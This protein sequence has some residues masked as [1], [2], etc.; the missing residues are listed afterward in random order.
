MPQALSVNL[1]PRRSSNL[2]AQKS[3]GPTNDIAFHLKASIDSY[4]TTDSVAIPTSRVNNLSCNASVFYFIEMQHQFVLDEWNNFHD[5]NGNIK[6]LAPGAAEAARSSTIIPSI[7]AAAAPSW[8]AITLQG[9]KTNHPTAP[10]KFNYLPPT[11]Q[12]AM[13]NGYSIGPLMQWLQSHDFSDKNNQ[14]TSSPLPLSSRTLLD[15]LNNEMS[16]SSEFG[17]SIP[18][19]E[20]RFL[21]MLQTA[22]R[23]GMTD[24]TSLTA[25]IFQANRPESMHFT[26]SESEINYPIYIPFSNWILE[27]WDETSLANSQKVIVRDENN[28]WSASF[29]KI[30]ESF[31]IHTTILLQLQGM[32]S[33]AVM[34]LNSWCKKDVILLK[35][36]ANRIADVASSLSIPGASGIGHSI[37]Q[38]V[39]KYEMI[40]STIME[41]PIQEQAEK[42]IEEMEALADQC[43]AGF[44]EIANLN[45]KDQQSLKRVNQLAKYQRQE[46]FLQSMQETKKGKCL[47][48]ETSQ[49]RSKSLHQTFV[50]VSDNDDEISDFEDMAFKPPEFPP[51]PPPTSS[52]F[53]VSSGFTH[54]QD[55]ETS[56]SSN[57][58][59]PTT[60]RTSVLTFS[61]NSMITELK[62]FNLNIND[63]KYEKIY[64]SLPAANQKTFRDS[65][66]DDTVSIISMA[67]ILSSAVFDRITCGTDANTQSLLKATHDYTELGSSDSYLNSDIENEVHNSLDEGSHLNSQSLLASHAGKQSRK[68]EAYLLWI[69]KWEFENWKKDVN[70]MKN[71]YVLLPSNLESNAS[72]IA[73]SRCMSI[74]TS[75][76]SDLEGIGVGAGPFRGHHDNEVA[77][78]SGGG[79]MKKVFKKI[80][81][82]GG[83]SKPN[84]ITANNRQKEKIIER[85]EGVTFSWDENRSDDNEENDGDVVVASIIVVRNM[86][87]E[88]VSFTIYPRRI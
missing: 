50:T 88:I 68:M 62:S 82:F 31:L 6:L 40:S 14:F 26:I 4:T 1:I 58:Y 56:D 13:P 71:A 76:R 21:Q 79:I 41:T 25:L 67:S 83:K 59:Q 42:N 30:D 17:D 72:P 77:H 15:S 87:G 39:W 20:I 46:I 12:L 53:E 65:V 47:Q 54:R 51:P 78:E 63:S 43:F 75:N 8:T 57:F 49:L 85:I 27:N 24:A 29:S 2:T 34:L 74:A 7:S 61:P 84:D 73:D 70:K 81:D 5:Q 28:T 48:N 45:D 36:I 3:L 32:A 55:S 38:E 16:Y 11:I 52:F 33:K 86:K 44:Q 80:G 60:K 66:S 19:K 69:I 10:T 23:L 18:C 35:A 64:R 37:M 9:L 22:N